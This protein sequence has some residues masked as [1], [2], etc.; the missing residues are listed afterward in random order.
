MLAGIVATLNPGAAPVVVSEIFD[1]LLDTACS[2][3]SNQGATADAYGQRS[4]RPGDFA[5][6]A[7]GVKCRISTAA[8][9]RP[10]EIK[11]GSRESLNYRTVFMR[12]PMLSDGS[13]LNP[14]HWLKI[15]GYLYNIFEVKR[16]QGFSGLH[17]LEIIVEQVIA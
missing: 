17:H 3:L 1:A 12:E 6:L 14:H 4:Q 7:D 8:L 2:V 11:V 5:S 15:D 10:H 9:G 13:T 16:V